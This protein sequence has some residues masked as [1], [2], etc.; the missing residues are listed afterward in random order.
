LILFFEALVKPVELPV[1]R[2]LLDLA[3]PF[4]GMALAQMPDEFEKL[5]VRQSFDCLFDFVQGR[6]AYILTSTKLGHQAQASK[7][8]R[9]CGRGIAWIS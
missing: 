9:P 6:H 3:V 1:V 5:L 7:G 8:P 4:L 2:I